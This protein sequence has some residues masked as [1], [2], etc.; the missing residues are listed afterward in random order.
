MDLPG[1]IHGWDFY[2]G[3]PDPD[4]DLGDGGG[5]GNVF[6]GTFVAGVAAA[7]SDNG[8]GVVG[9]SWYRPDHAVE[10]VHECGRCA[11]GGHCRGNTVRG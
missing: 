1:D 4:P 3:G 5:D 8:I 11:V 7:V 10:G 2:N 6:H 9:A